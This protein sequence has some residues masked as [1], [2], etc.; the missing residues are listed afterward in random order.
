[1]ID[2]ANGDIKTEILKEK[3]QGIV[4]APEERKLEKTDVPHEMIKN[5]FHTDPQAKR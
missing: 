2:N 4:S 3:Q 5:I 1:M